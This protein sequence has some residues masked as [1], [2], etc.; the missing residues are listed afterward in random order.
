MTQVSHKAAN[1]KLDVNPD[2]IDEER[3][4][5]NSR[6]KPKAKQ[7]TVDAKQPEFAP[8]GAGAVSTHQLLC[9]TSKYPRYSTGIGIFSEY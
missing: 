5:L 7:T 4:A 6:K 1:R 8:L 9:S 2:A 3:G